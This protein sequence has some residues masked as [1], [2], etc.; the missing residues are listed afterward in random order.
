VDSLV[1]GADATS[2]SIKILC[3][4]GSYITMTETPDTFD[5]QIE[6]ARDAEG[7]TL[8]T[9]SNLADF[10]GFRQTY[11]AT[12]ATTFIN[13]ARFLHVPVAGEASGGRIIDC[14]WDGET[15][16]CTRASEN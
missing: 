1:L 13:N 8:M 14:E 5:A 6:S 10:N 11:N 15:L 3:E 7:R 9:N 4:D 2:L 16:T 12:D